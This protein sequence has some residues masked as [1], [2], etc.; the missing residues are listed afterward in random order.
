MAELTLVN[1]A[2]PTQI[3][4]ALRTGHVS[5]APTSPGTGGGDAGDSK[6]GGDEDVDA[7]AEE[8]YSKILILMDTARSRNG[9]PYL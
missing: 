9:E 7:L 2:P 5:A 4:A 6:K 1:A 3:A 8:V